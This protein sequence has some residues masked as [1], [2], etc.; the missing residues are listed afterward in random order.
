M[1]SKNFVLR[2]FIANRQ[3]FFFVV[4]I[5]KKE[6]KRK[7]FLQIVQIINRNMLRHLSNSGFQNGIDRTQIVKKV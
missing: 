2:D 1:Y 5:H 6:N 3:C 7:E 4:F